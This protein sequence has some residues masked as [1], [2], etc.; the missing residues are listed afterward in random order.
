VTASG[1][2]TGFVGDL[3][4]SC[5]FP[6]VLSMP[7]G[8]RR[9]PGVSVLLQHLWLLAGGGGQGERLRC[10][11]RTDLPCVDMMTEA[12]SDLAFPIFALFV[13]LAPVLTCWILTCFFL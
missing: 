10:P 13:I 2:E 3:G 7:S 11:L 4:S 8:R 12:F 1:L 6:Q 5:H 9:C